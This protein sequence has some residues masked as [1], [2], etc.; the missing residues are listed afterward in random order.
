MKLP[1]FVRRPPALESNPIT[2]TLNNA[3]RALGMTYRLGPATSIGAGFL[4][5]ALV[6]EELARRVAALEAQPK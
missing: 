4:P 3:A 1:W 5:L 2:E 6:I